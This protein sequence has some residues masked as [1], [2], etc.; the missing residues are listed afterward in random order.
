M[1]YPFFILFASFVVINA[2]AQ[3]KQKPYK[4]FSPSLI[5]IA[6]SLQNSAAFQFSGGF[7]KKNFNI[8]IAAGLD[9]CLL[10]TL[11]LKIESTIYPI[12]NNNFF[13]SAAGGVNF[14]VPKEGER[15]IYFDWW[16][17]QQAKYKNGYVA[18]LGLG[19]SFI[20]KT[21]RLDV[22]LLWSR[23]TFT[24]QFK[25][26]VYDGTNTGKEFPFYNQYELNRIIL[27][28]SYQFRW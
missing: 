10:R 9:F 2:T 23:K 18:E 25:S 13:I 5:A 12:R 16:Q 8:G 17:Q 3:V 28:S 15:R 24:E 20:V 4:Y 21:N 1:K 7:G 22:S 11:P 14:T 26:W 19:Y 6:G 27:K